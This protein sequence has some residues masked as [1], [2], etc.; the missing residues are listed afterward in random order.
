[1]GRITKYYKSTG[2]R[3]SSKKSKKS[4]TTRRGAYGSLRGTGFAPL[5]AFAKTLRNPVKISRGLNPF[6]NVKY[7]RHKYVDVITIPAG[8]SA[9]WPQLYQFR[10]NSMY[11]PDYTGT[12]H[13]PLFRDEMAAQYNYYTV[14]SSFIKVLVPPENTQ[15]RNW[16]LFVDDEATVPDAPAIFEQHRIKGAVKLDKRN[17]PLKLTCMYDAAKWNK[18]SVS[19]IMGEND[20]KVQKTANPGSATVKFYTLYAGPLNTSTTLDALKVT[21]EMFFFVAWRE[22]VDHTVS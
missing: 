10:A 7:V 6:P 20:Q 1:M 21:V 12:G 19:S 11:D 8:S 9:G 22:P 3:K 18:T 14:L 17:T 2:K 13:Q 15:E 4:S 16:T 5:R